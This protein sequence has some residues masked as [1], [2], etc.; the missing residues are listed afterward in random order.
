MKVATQ[1]I[2]HCQVVLDIEVEDA[3]L[4]KAVDQAYR[5]LVGRM[6]VPGFRRGKAPRALVERMVGR[7]A[8]I[9]DAVEQLVPVVVS[10]AVKQH[11]LKMVARPSLEVVTT[12][13]LQVKATV[14]VQPKIQLG[15]YASL[16][17]ELKP[18]TVDEDEVNQ[19]IQRLRES[20]AT[21][22]PVERTVQIGDRVAMDLRGVVGDNV[23]VDANDAEYIVNPDGPQPAPGFVDQVVGVSAE[24]ERQFAL[25][26]PDDY[27]NKDLAGAEATF[28][29]KVHWVKERKLPDL[30]D[31]LAS[32]VD[33][34]YETADQLVAAVRRQ[35]L[36]RDEASKRA[37]HEDEVVNAVVEQA[38]ADVPPQLVDEEQERLL[39][40]LQSSIQR[41]GLTYE[42]YLRFTQNTADTLIDGQ[43]D[44]AQR[45]VIRGAVLDAV[46][47]AE[48]LDPS[49]DEIQ[50]EISL[51]FSD[52][53]EV[54]RMI[55]ATRER[56]DVR[57]RI[58][59][60]IR[61]RKAAQFLM[62]TV[63]GIDSGDPATTSSEPEETEVPAT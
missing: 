16:K 46:A 50:A 1:E 22:E 15:D 45:N 54:R 38:S 58:A 55:K 3:R 6:N 35:I 9:E 61:L 56:D 34:E 57:E 29:V 32:T 62:K 51:A 28:T 24:D 30:D 19:V 2:E 53:R 42:Q 14:P 25:A 49:D 11:D 20:N 40:S 17:V 7:S 5:R 44:R 21:W 48:G 36:D 41:S 4:E 27:R 37:D 60:G 63:G 8:L 39:A 12:E 18:A 10:E 43:R 26:L 23:F 47:L 13:P 52:E 31:E 33:G 59:R